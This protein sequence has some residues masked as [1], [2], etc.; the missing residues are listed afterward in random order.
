M[1]DK[2]KPPQN[3]EVFKAKM[4]K[5]DRRL[6]LFHVDCIQTFA[7]F[8]NVERDMISFIN[9]INKTCNMN[10]NLLVRVVHFNETESFGCV[11][12]FNSTCFH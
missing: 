7:A 6:D 5:Y 9:L 10:K 12:E 2:K 1:R 3:A 8:D 11:E 4:F